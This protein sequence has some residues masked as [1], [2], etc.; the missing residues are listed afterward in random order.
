[1]HLCCHEDLDWGNSGSP[2][3]GSTYH[4]ILFIPRCYLNICHLLSLSFLC[5]GTRDLTG[6][7]HVVS[8][9]S[10]AFFFNDQKRKYKQWCSTISPLSTKHVIITRPYSL[11][12]K[13][14]LQK[15]HWESRSWLETVKNLYLLECLP[16]W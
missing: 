12:V 16:F 14:I 15:W 2:L 8:H 4:S 10:F 9:S 1:M 3:I 11:N 13:K 5:C 6:V 7:V